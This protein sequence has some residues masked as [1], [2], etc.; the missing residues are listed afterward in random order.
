[1]TT[2][3]WSE[4][5]SQEFLDH[6]DLFVPERETQLDAVCSLIHPGAGDVVELCCGDGTLA[7]AIL[8]RHPGCTLHGLDG[9][10]AMLERASSRLASAGTR[11]RPRRFELAETGWRADYRGCAG[12]VS[13]LAVHHLSDDG[14]R[15]LFEDV[16]A[17]LAP[18]GVFVLADVVEPATPASR[19]LAARQWDDAVRRRSFARFGDERGLD[20]FRRLRWNSYQ[21]GAEDP[22]DIDHLAG[23]ADH[24]A[25]L[26]ASFDAVDVVWAHAGH[27][28]FAAQTRGG[29]PPRT[30]GLVDSS[31]DL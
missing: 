31:S 2:P 28:I 22:D 8:E 25:W 1:M 20:E 30:P 19:A 17:M 3:H 18:G 5:N 12:V 14:K 10:A 13:S 6:G 29:R 26:R 4:A 7:A 11:F 23:A 27:V 16:A 24:V 9:S 21:P 15:R